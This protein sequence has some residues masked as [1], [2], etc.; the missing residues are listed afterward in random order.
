MTR[1]PEDP[2]VSGRAKNWQ[3]GGPA[4][5]HYARRIAPVLFAPW[6]AVLM[7]RA[8][9]FP[10]SAVLD[11]ACGTGVVAR[12][13]A[14]RSGVRGKVIGLDS[15]PAML[16]VARQAP[17]PHGGARIEWQH[18]NALELPFADASFDRVLC[19]QGFQFFEDRRAAAREA[20]R[21]LRP[22]GQV[23][24]SVWSHPDHN[25]LATALI[26]TLGQY[27]G[28]RTARAMA[29]PFS[30]APGEFEASIKEAG[31]QISE[32][33]EVCLEVRVPDAKLFIYGLLSALPFASE[34]EA[35]DQDLLVRDT[36]DRLSFA[37][38]G[39][40]MRLPTRAYIIVATRSAAALSQGNEN[41]RGMA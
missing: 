6:A 14:L 28:C 18:G 23:A 34:I 13:A 16:A 32:R 30:L 31:F 15:N 19:Q 26:E 38:D 17:L 9:L 2:V 20:A 36:L 7:N 41:L 37:I 21:V 24:A 40:G 8:A 22:G 10:G 4:A 3:L 11:L 39:P 5:L 12:I 1:R 25:P 27:A 33:G 29:V 35:L